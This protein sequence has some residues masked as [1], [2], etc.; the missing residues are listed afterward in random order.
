MPCPALPCLDLPRPALPRLA[1]ACLA[2][3]CPAS[4]R[5]DLPCLDPPVQLRRVDSLRKGP[6]PRGGRAGAKWP[7]GRT[8]FGFSN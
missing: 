3:A 8:L 1:L 7:D 4:T 5:L 2:L 6:Y